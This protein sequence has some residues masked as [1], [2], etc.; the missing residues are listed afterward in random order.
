MESVDTCKSHDD[1]CDNQYACPKV[2][3]ITQCSNGGQ[4]DIQHIKYQLS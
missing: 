4:M 1:D 2:T 3:E